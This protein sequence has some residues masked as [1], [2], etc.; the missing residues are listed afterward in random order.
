MHK[1][2]YYTSLNFLRAVCFA[3]KICPNE[4]VTFLYFYKY[5]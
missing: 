1:G 3:F 2:F 5:G 4:R